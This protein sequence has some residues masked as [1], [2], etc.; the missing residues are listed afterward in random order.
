M[1]RRVAIP[2]PVRVVDVDDRAAAAARVL[3]RRDHPVQA[4]AKACEQRACILVLE[5]V[6]HVDDE[7]D[8]HAADPSARPDP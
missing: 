4:L 7:Q 5:A 2:L 1:C 8:L 3:E 6:D